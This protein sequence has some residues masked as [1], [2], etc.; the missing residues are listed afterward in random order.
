VLGTAHAEGPRLG[1]EIERE[2]NRHSRVVSYGAG[3]QP[4]WQFASGNVIDRVEL[5]IDRS[6][7][8]RANAWREREH[9]TKVFLRIR[10]KGKATE[11]V[12]YYVRGGVGRSVG[13]E[14]SYNYAYIEPG[15]KYELGR[16]WEW[17]LGFREIDS[18]DGTAGEH[19]HKLIT[20]PSYSFD[21]HHEVELRYSHGWGDKRVRAWSLEYVYKF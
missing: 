11:S 20:G 3:M 8:E 12:A 2:K 1:I 10:H 14:Q 19:V 13:A 16:G 7:D 17:T 6:L 21:R 4:G 18:I 15:L 9:E 5:L